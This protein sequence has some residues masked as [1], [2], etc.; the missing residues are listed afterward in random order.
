CRRA[1]PRGGAFPGRG[2]PLQ[3]GSHDQEISGP[4]IRDPR[5]ADGGIMLKQL[6]RAAVAAFL[7]MPALTSAA[8][9]SLDTA[10]H[11]SIREAFCPKPAGT[12]PAA[13][14][15]SAEPVEPARVFDNLYFVGDRSTSAWAL[16]TSEGIILLD[17][18]FQHNVEGT[19]VGGL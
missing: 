12:G 5:S 3:D 14:Q 9:P 17:A 10:V 11:D 13:P 19:I 18:G 16:T 7:S 4:V 6:V 1:G 15:Q 2:G 8:A